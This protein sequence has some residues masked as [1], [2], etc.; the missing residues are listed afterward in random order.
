MFLKI[1]FVFFADYN[2]F[3]LLIT[4]FF[5]FEKYT[6]A[7]YTFLLFSPNRVL[8]VLQTTASFLW[9]KYS[10]SRFLKFSHFANYGFLR[11]AKYSFACFENN[12]STSCQRFSISNFA[13]HSISPLAK[14]S[15]FENY[16]FSP[17]P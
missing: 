8:L 7:C 12:S 5:C 3:I 1:T 6:F 17:F 14:Y 16:C 9:F 11:F 13:N 15:F 4:V 2:F 10:F